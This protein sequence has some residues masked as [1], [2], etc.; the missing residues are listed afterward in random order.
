MV[1]FYSFFSNTLSK[2]IVL[3]LGH[4]KPLKWWG[5]PL[6]PWNLGPMSRKC[7][8]WCMK[9]TSPS[10]GGKYISSL[11]DKS[12]VLPSEVVVKKLL[13]PES[14]P[15]CEAPSGGSDFTTVHV[16]L[17]GSN[18]MVPM[19][20]SCGSVWASAKLLVLPVKLLEKVD[21]YIHNWI[22]YTWQNFY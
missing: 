14:L 12:S 1:T 16:A 17:L 6:K 8:T 3:L 22:I 18:L 15:V 20:N 9:G 4:R 10:G 7:S 13:N 5:H 11:A 2:C 19:V 21:N